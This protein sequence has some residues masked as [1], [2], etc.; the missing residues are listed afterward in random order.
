M[1]N[2]G[3]ALPP[4]FA[5]ASKSFHLPNA[6]VKGSSVLLRAVTLLSKFA[7]IFVLARY[8]TPTEVG[9]F[10]LL[11]AS[12][13]YALMA[14]GL[15]FYSYANRAMIAAPEDQWA[16][17][18]RDQCVFYLLSYIV[19]LPTLLLIFSFDLLPW[20]L[21]FWFF[22]LLVVEHLA[23]ELNRL[24]VAIKRPMWASAILFV[25]SGIWAIVVAALLWFYPSMRTLPVVLGGWVIGAGAACLLGVICLRDVD[26]KSLSPRINWRWITSGLKVALP[27]A[28]ATLAF[29]AIYTMDRYW[30]E[31]LAGIEAL[32]AYVLFA[33]M[34][35]AIMNFLDAS[36]FSFQYPKLLGATSQQDD[37]L[38]HLEMKHLWR[39][40]VGASAILSLGVI[41]LAGPI[42]AWIG[43]PLYADH[44]SMLYWAVAAVA[45][46]SVSMVPHYGLYAIHA[47][48]V[49][50]YSHIISL[51]VFALVS[52][53]LI[54]LMNHTAVLGGLVASSAFIL[55][56]KWLAFKWAYR[57]SQKNRSDNF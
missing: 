3:S 48:R 1:N 44:I 21:A 51:P 8:L 9:L 19:L 41:A 40:T 26:L 27:F 31:H 29:R 22:S 20:S 2:S 25:R 56:V 42:I 24:L 23:Q 30:I 39:N 45:L 53:K 33:G 10:G 4:F 18:L 47:D 46:F 50:V 49:I 52:W 14:L 12:V 55:I 5:L 54:P 15:D 57:P 16:S 35:N 6:L 11:A 38:F 28:I 34:A 32:A 17:Q 37:Q 13:T 7:L 43:R 36:V